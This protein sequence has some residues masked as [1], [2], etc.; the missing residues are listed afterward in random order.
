VNLRLKAASDPTTGLFTR[1]QALA[2]GYSDAAIYAR[3]RKGEWHRVRFGIYMLASTWATLDAA[4]KHRTSAHAVALRCGD[5]TVF[6]HV[7]GAVIRGWPIWGI[8]LDEV[9]VTRR[10]GHSGRMEAGV[11][12]FQGP[13]PDEQTEVVDGLRVSSRERLMAE[14]VRQYELEQAVVICDAGLR[15]GADRELTHQIL[16]GRYH[17]SKTRRAMFPLDFAD[18]RAANPAESRLRLLLHLEG[19][20]DP[21]PQ[22]EIRD[23]NGR[24]IAYGDLLYAEQHVL[25]EFDGKL[26]YGAD[27]DDQDPRER[28]FKEKLRED[29]IR[30]EAG[31]EIVRVTWADLARPAV[32]AARIR[33]AFARA[34]ARRGRAA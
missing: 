5:D 23:R 4:G 8:P 21:E 10:K 2:S 30:E 1:S 6:S 31:L 34:A 24:V 18:G 11:H 29:Y 25:V 27:L 12:H 26:K 22:A 9:N 32:I 14:A 13:I 3:I 33:A 28:L 15:D 16:L 17:W 20:P 19:L 7:T